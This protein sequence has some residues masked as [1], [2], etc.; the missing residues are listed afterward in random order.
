MMNKR[1]V[2]TF[3]AESAFVI[4]PSFYRELGI[5]V[6]LFDLDNTLAP[7]YAKSVPPAAKTLVNAL[8]KEGFTLAILSN[9]TTPKLRRFAHE[10]GL[11]AYGGA[12]KPFGFALRR[13]LKKQ[14]WAKEETLLIGDQILTDVLAANSA[15]IRSILTEP[16]AKEEPLWTKWNRLYERPIRRKLMREK[17]VPSWKEKA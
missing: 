14:R 16:L 5:R 13:L 12:M 1:F 6:I 2:P 8:E 17:L 3:W 15:G 7:Y 11:T 4:P 10:L 9:N